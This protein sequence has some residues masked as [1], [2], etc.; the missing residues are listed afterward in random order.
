[1]LTWMENWLHGIIAVILFAVLVELLLPNSKFLKYTRLV[2]GLI[3]L[4]TILSPLLKIFDQNYLTQIDASYTLWEKQLNST[5]QKTLSLSEIQAKA[6]DI[7]EK[8]TAATLELTAQTITSQMEQQIKQDGINYIAKIEVALK[9]QENRGAEE[10][11]IE[12]V[13]VYA[14]LSKLN[15][16][17]ASQADDAVKIVDINP[18]EIGILDKKTTSEINTELAS[19]EN[20]PEADIALIYT[21]LQRNWNINKAIISIVAVDAEKR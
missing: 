16:I 12:S 7:E 14:S 10:P 3:L 1:M 13:Y 18:V 17:N 11:V 20:I 4:I 19:L 21:T 6:K 2:I 9:M 5:E 8:R 15:S